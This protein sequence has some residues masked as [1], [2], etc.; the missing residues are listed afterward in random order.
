M[1][2]S[3]E[4]HLKP[5]AVA[6]NILQA[7]STR[8][9][10]VLLALANLYR[11]FD[12]D[13]IEAVVRERMLARFELRWKKGAGKDQILLILAVFF[14]PYIRGYCF[15][16]GA[17]TTTALVGMAISAFERFYGQTPD[18]EFT[19][20][21]IDYS[22]AEKEFSKEKMRLDYHERAGEQ[23]QSVRSR[24][25]MPDPSLAL[26]MSILIY[27]MPTSREY[28]PGWT[29]PT[30]P[31]LSAPVVMGLSS[32]LSAFS[33]SSPT[34]VLR[35]A[36]SAILVTSKPSAAIALQSNVSVRP[37]Q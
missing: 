18:P 3:V 37:R 14:N 21:L 1:F 22:N 19:S 23:T 29:S 6:T 10:H 36:F 8:L 35:N 32:S 34:P 9:D 13:D 20:A 31:M 11:M 7:S 12:S 4:V 26:I 2:D 16:R 30:T 27:R 28:G 17:V 15:N 5:I 33:P 25:S 24:S